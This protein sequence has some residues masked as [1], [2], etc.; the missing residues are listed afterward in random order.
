MTLLAAFLLGLAAGFIFMAL[1]E[2]KH[3]RQFKRERRRFLA[4]GEIP[5]PITEGLRAACLLLDKDCGC[6]APIYASRE[7][8]DAWEAVREAIQAAH[9]KYPY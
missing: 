8:Y 1:L 7:E 6:G 3:I 4:G 9:K 2:D 5:D